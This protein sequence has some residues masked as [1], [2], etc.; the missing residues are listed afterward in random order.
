MEYTTYNFRLFKTLYLLMCM[1][2]P[3]IAFAGDGYDEFQQNGVIC[4][5]GYPT[6]TDTVTITQA[7]YDKYYASGTAAHSFY[8][9]KETTGADGV[10][11]FAY[12][13]YDTKFEYMTAAKEGTTVTL[14]DTVSTR[15]LWRIYTDGNHQFR[16]ENVARG[17]WLKLETDNDSAVTL[18]L[19]NDTMQS[20]AIFHEKRDRVL[21]ISNRGRAF[22]FLKTT[23]PAKVT[24]EIYVYYN[25]DK[26]A[27][28]ATTAQSKVHACY[29]EMWEYRA[30]EKA[31]SLTSSI[32]NATGDVSL[33]TNQIV[34]SYADSA[35]MVGNNG[36][37]EQQATLSIQAE[38]T[39]STY[40]HNIPANICNY[41]PKRLVVSTERVDNPQVKFSPVWKDPN[42]KTNA[43]EQQDSLHYSYLHPIDEENRPSKN[44]IW[45]HSL[46]AE[47]LGLT[48][49]TIPYKEYGGRN[50]LMFETPTSTN[51]QWQAVVRPV[52]KSPIDMCLWDGAY[53]VRYKDTLVVTATLADSTVSAV[54]EVSVER[55]S[56]HVMSDYEI[57]PHLSAAVLEFEQGGG[58]LTC[59]LDSIE[60]MAGLRV[61]RA[62]ERFVVHEVMERHK[63]VYQGLSNHGIS[64]TLQVTSPYV[65]MSVPTWMTI[66][67]K[68]Q[69]DGTVTLTAQANFSGGMRTAAIQATVSKQVGNKVETGDALLTFE[70]K[71][72]NDT[73]AAKFIPNPGVS[74]YPLTEDHRQQVHTMETTIYYH[75]GENITLRLKERNFFGYMR[76]Y[77]YHSGKDPQYHLEADGTVTELPKFWVKGPMKDATTP[78]ESLNANAQE[79]HGLFCMPND[80]NDREVSTERLAAPIIHLAGGISMDIACDVSNYTDYE[81]I[82]GKDI[83]GNDSI[84][85]LKEPTL[86]YRQ[87]FHLRPAQEIADQLDAYKTKEDK[88]F[89]EYH[90]VVPLG[91][92]YVLSSKYVH[93]VPFEDNSELC[94]YLNAQYRTN[95]GTGDW[96]D[97]LLRLDDVS[98]NSHIWGYWYFNGKDCNNGI[99]GVQG[100]ASPKHEHSSKDFINLKHTTNGNTQLWDLIQ[101]GGI[102]T[103]T[104]DCKVVSKG[105]TNNEG[106]FEWYGASWGGKKQYGQG[107]LKNGGEI[108]FLRFIIDYVD[109]N[110]YGPSETELVSL[111]DIEENY[112]MLCQ[113][114][115]DFDT[116][117]TMEQTLY[118][119]PLPIK[120]STFGFSY[121][122]AVIGTKVCRRTPWFDKEHKDPNSIYFPYFGE[123]A[124]VNKV[125]INGWL[126]ETAQHGAGTNEAG[127]LEAAKKGY[128]L[129]VDGAQ[130]PGKVV[131]LSTQARICS[132]QQLYCAAWVCN[133]TEKYG[134]GGV[135]PI[136]RFDVEGRVAG[137][138]WEPVSS[139]YTGEIG[140]DKGWQ[141]IRFPLVSARDYDESRVTVYNFAA[142]TKDNDFLI[143]DVWLYASR[144]PLTAYQTVTECVEGSSDEEFVASVIRVDYTNFTGEESTTKNVYYQFYNTTNDTPVLGNYYVHSEDDNTAAE[145]ECVAGNCYGRIP[146]P[147]KNFEPTKGDSIYSD[148]EAF[149]A[150]VKKQMED[151]SADDETAKSVKEDGLAKIGF[152]KAKNKKLD[153]TYDEHWVMYVVQMMPVAKFNS[154]DKYEVRMAYSEQELLT[155]DL[156]CALRTNLPVYEPTSFRFNGITYPAEGQCA[157]GLYPIEMLVQQVI[158]DQD[159]KQ[160]VTLS[161]YAKGDWLKGMH[162]DDVYY[163]AYL[164]GESTASNDSLKAYDTDARYK[165]YYGYERTDIET[166]IKRMRRETL[167]RVDQNNHPYYVANPNFTVSD[168]TM[169]NFNDSCWVD[170]NMQGDSFEQDD[171]Q[172]RYCDVIK[173]LCNRGLLSLYK[174]RDYFYMHSADTIRYW[175]FPIARTAKDTYR[176]E[177]YILNEC[178]IPKYIMVFTDPS[179]YVLDLGQGTIPDG[180]EGKITR[181]RVPLSLANKQVS[182]PIRA[183]GDDVVLAWNSTQLE[184]TTDPNMAKQIGQNTFRL[185]YAQDRRYDPNNPKAYY[186]KGDTIHFSPITN[187][188][189]NSL[190]DADK[191]GLNANT[192]TMRAGYEYTMRIQMVTKTGQTTEENSNCQIGHT[193]FTVVVVPDTLLWTPTVANEEGQY[194]WG[195]DRN[196]RGIANG[197]TM[198]QG[199]A[200]LTSTCVILP[201]DLPDTQY[202]YIESSATRYP[203]DVNYA[204]NICRKVQ[205]F[206]NAKLLGQQYLQYDSAYV[207][208][209]MTSS[210]WYTMAAPLQ[211]VYSGDF[212]I[213]HTGEYGGTGTNA[214]QNI[215]SSKPFEVQSFSGTRSRFAPYAFWTSY[216]N[217]NVTKVTVYG[218]E[219]ITSTS[220]T[221]LPSNALNETLAPAQGFAMLGFGPNDNKETLVVRLPEPDTEYHFYA[222][223]QDG[224]PGI[225]TGQ[226]VSLSRTNA[227]RFAFTPNSDGNMEVTIHNATP[228][229][230][231]LFGNPTMAYLNVFELIKVHNSGL[232]STELESKYLLNRFD[233]ISDDAWQAISAGIAAERDGWIAPMQSVRLHTTKEMLQLTLTIKP[234]FLSLSRDDNTTARHNP[235]RAPE[236]GHSFRREVMRMVAYTPDAAGYATL[237]AIDFA[238]NDFDIMEDMP[239]TSSGIEQDVNSATATTPVNL[240][241]LA[242]TQSL[243]VD[244]R[245]QIGVVPLGFVIAD[246]YRTDSI[247]LYFGLSSTW[248]TECYLCDNQTGMRYHIYNDTRIRIATPRNHEIRYYIQCPHKEPDEPNT[249]TGNDDIPANKDGQH[250]IAISN[251]P[252]NVVSNSPGCHCRTACVRHVRSAPD[253]YYPHNGYP[254]LHP[255]A[256]FGRGADRSATCKW[257]Y[258]HLQNN[259]QMKSVV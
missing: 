106:S 194:A 107:R 248:Q 152:V 141:Q 161:G 113:Y 155:N 18:Q 148:A 75:P 39:N 62:D 197:K 100:N 172:I 53:W 204:P 228:N 229:K 92:E 119:K 162:T 214:P 239:F 94:Y 232:S 178:A 86:S 97:T 12:Y 255:H 54:S 216:F 120:E 122:K 138:E 96:R 72:L 55:V 186:L 159:T 90:C 190:S 143:D 93:A 188:Y 105:G 51:S 218:N 84:I 58:T 212:F 254:C 108:K 3:L 130:Q 165:Q 183:I 179:K 160:E 163:R 30:D 63:Y 224:K 145:E 28:Y 36:Y 11:S 215:E 210:H 24:D 22:I 73:G 233:Y 137:G 32:S 237:A 207:D 60:E 74:G 180:Y 231:F 242:G 52:G 109:K 2:S 189:I 164:R 23:T 70:Q 250:V 5:F 125:G 222:P 241:T 26:R 201:S 99:P 88:W 181:V 144:L 85:S 8:E 78:F 64:C 175:I 208:V 136:L 217:R 185:A 247:T 200:P 191:Q 147:A 246:D 150:A 80:I 202:P 46:N 249:P 209:P 14:E 134:E 167:R 79:S 187:E 56:C 71:G 118:S 257:R 82:I 6:K 10:V 205:L 168:V 19:V 49:D 65:G 34:F 129:Y 121:P 124:I 142:T 20:S 38:V 102:H 135:P 240:Y 193:Y 81:L 221:F 9:R 110:L 171:K 158:T 69:D 17:Q 154:K 176:G 252:Q 184:Q 27:P 37:T 227:H 128:C 7:E 203:I 234:D 21:N 114:H 76:W 57:K 13:R 43:D 182:V 126:R 156:Q 35:I 117:L 146:R 251:A 133:V 112:I 230:E 98:D 245:D 199:Y 40:Y 235:H 206:A 101:S 253:A 153:G 149:I 220:A 131:S 151:L 177:E 50:V 256:A 33:L 44:H 4:S 196:W 25:A 16:Y 174:E 192:A 42:T 226:K 211:D 48:F 87:I 219:T 127:T 91:V 173:D 95:Y 244:I 115:F 140:N 223:S 47:Q 103:D 169:L 195:D 116:A 83:Q 89:E 238:N 61:Y 29:Y 170:E 1:V 166:A 132:G 243:S 111:R 31:L 77:D 68:P 259:S 258:T 67:K 213:P 104:L 15:A 157:N 66:D 225:E 123:Y 45:R 139:F 198:S 41:D 236:T 59:H